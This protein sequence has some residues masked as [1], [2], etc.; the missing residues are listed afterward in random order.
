VRALRASVMMNFKKALAFF[1]LFYIWQISATE[2]TDAWSMSQATLERVFTV[3]LFCKQ[4]LQTGKFLQCELDVLGLKHPE[5]GKKLENLTVFIKGG[6]PAHHHGLPTQPEV[7]WSGK[8]HT[9]RVEG[10]KFSM[11]GE[12][13]LRFFIHD[14]ANKLKDVATFNIKI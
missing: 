8:Q 13:Q 2:A 14:K 11:P 9:N 10:L 1:L 6:M 4:P 5:Q 7:T 12:W 3:N